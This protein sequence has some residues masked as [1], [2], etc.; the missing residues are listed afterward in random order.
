MENILKCDMLDYLLK[1]EL[2]SQHQ[3]GFLYKHSTCT[4]L[5]ECVSDWTRKY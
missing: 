3:H 4:Q 1:H 5:L 2:T